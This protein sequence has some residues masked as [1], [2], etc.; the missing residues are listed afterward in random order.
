MDDA[1]QP[2]YMCTGTC[3]A[4]ITKEQYDNGLT[5]CG[6]KECT[7]YGQPFVKVETSQ[8]EK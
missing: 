4:V 2:A 8:G 3:K 6:T 1:Q 7:M 5:T